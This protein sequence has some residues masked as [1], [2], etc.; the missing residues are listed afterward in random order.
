MP[1]FVTDSHPDCSGWAVEKDDGELLGCHATKQDAVD[2][3]VAVSLAEDIEPG[4]E[5][6][7]EDRQVDLELPDYI[8]AAA[9]QGIEWHEEGLSGDGVVPRTVRE[10]R[11]MAAG[12]VTEDKVVRVAA[13]AARHAVD[14][15][16]DGARPG[17]DGFPTP[18]AVAHYLWGIPT[19][20]RY[21]D[22]VSWF[23][24][25]AAQVKAEEGR[26]VVTPVEPRSKGSDVEFRSVTAE[27]REVGDGNTFVGYAARF[28]SPSQPLPFIERIAPGAFSRTLRARRDVRLFINHDSGQVLASKRSG[29]L[30]LAEDEY[31]L[32]VEAD[33][34]DTQAARDLKELMR[35]GVVDSM[36]F[37][38]TVPRGGDRWSDDGSER[39]LRE[40][41][42]HEVSVVTGFPAYE[43][44][45][46]AVRSLDGLAERTGLSV[47]ELSTTFEALAAG[48]DV[49]PARVSALVDV[50]QDALP[51][52]EAPTAPPVGLLSKKAE[53]LAK[54]PPAQVA[55]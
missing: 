6:T 28:N 21:A 38:F 4:G 39:E 11:D 26:A 53:L 10:A 37:G 44:T 47:D 48:D 12:R 49:D 30:R 8:R 3:M 1:Y 41:V 20:S 46:A 9:A 34:P 25:K 24:R 29:T 55:V 22:A 43:A 2:Q 36:S 5:R 19:G 14:L 40:V 33:L 45:S 17:E 42:L 35:R 32:R 13:W 23:E 7:S 52:A 50:L 18:G 51:K 27:L 16:T 54:R 31:G 15:E